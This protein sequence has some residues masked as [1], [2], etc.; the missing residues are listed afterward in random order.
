[1]DVAGRFPTGGG[2]PSPHHL[3]NQSG[4][5]CA[6]TEGWAGF[7]PHMVDNRAS[8]RWTDATY[9]DLEQDRTEN[10]SGMGETSFARTGPTGSE[11]HLVEGQVA[12][13]LWDVK[14]SRID[15][16][17]DKEGHNPRGRT[18]DDLAM[19]DDEIVGTLRAA[20]Y[21]S[22]GDFYAAWESARAQAHSARNV[23]ELHAMGFVGS[24]RPLVDPFGGLDKWTG[25]GTLNWR[26]GA[27]LEGGQPP[28]HQAGNTV[29]RARYC[30]GECVLTLRDGVDLSG[31]GAAELSLWRF[32]DN[33]LRAGDYLRVD[34]S[35]DGGSSWSA[36]RTWGPGS[37][38]DDRWHREAIPLT[39]YLD[40]TDFKVRLAAR[41][42][43][44][45]S[46]AAVDDVAINGTARARAGGPPDVLS[47]GFGTSLEGWT[48]RQV[49]AEGNNRMYCGGR[50]ST[51]YSLSHSQEHNGSAY[52]NH[53]RTCWFGAAG[54]ARTFSVPASLNGTDLNATARFQSFT[55]LPYSTGG[56]TNNL[57]ML[58][59]DSAGNVV[60]SGALFQGLRNTVVR[61]TGLRTATLAMPSFDAGRCP[62]TA[63]VHLNDHWRS[64]WDQRFYLDDLRI[65]GQAP[66]TCEISLAKPAMDV[67]SIARGT[68]ISGSDTQTV[69]NDG[70]LPVSSLSVAYSRIT[71]YDARGGPTSFTLPPSGAELRS[72]AA[73][74]AS[75]TPASSLVQFGS[76]PVGGSLDIQYRF[77]L[78]SATAIPAAVRQL[79]QT[80]TYNVVCAAAA[81]GAAAPPAGEGAP[82]A[83]PAPGHERAS[84]LRALIAPH[85]ATAPSPEGP[86]EPAPRPPGPPPPPPWAGPDVR[87]LLAG[88]PPVHST[89]KAHELL[90]MHASNGTRIMITEK[91]AYDADIVVDWDDHPGADRY[92]VVVHRAD[93]PRNRTADANV[94]ESR[95][96][97][98]GLDPSTEYVVRVGVRGDDST[99]ST[100]R[101]TT[102]PAG[103]AAL[104]PGLRLDASLRPASDRID[105]R[106][107]DT[108]GIRGDGRH[109]LELSVDGGPF[110]PAGASRTSSDSAEQ[111]IRPGWLGSTLAYRVSERIG[112]Q[113]H[114]YSEN[115]T[116]RLPASL[117]APSNLAVAPPSA[118]SGT[119]LSLGWDHA[120]LFRHYIV[121]AQRADG[122]WERIGRTQ[123]NSLDYAP[124]RGDGIAEYTFRVHAQL[125]SAASPPSDTATVRA[126]PP[127][128]PP[129]GGVSGAGSGP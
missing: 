49:P 4:A 24:A 101:A 40:S 20:T 99:Q 11:G 119:A 127:P 42:S 45:T 8:L 30:A 129:G 106:W 29:A 19:G 38:N 102:L 71:G 47:S 46:D 51:A 22:F 79:A 18:L 72:P 114:L 1:M 125:G 93:S 108:N 62:C 53:I 10:S 60:A 95:Y 92:K 118:A 64:N 2:C 111:A 82:P 77:N 56:H 13:A 110:G 17:F 126:A 7:V 48:Y 37:G 120:P 41:L 78:G 87:G 113:Q 75:W 3:H 96:R 128:P 21:S 25:S 97:F 12:A 105:L 54:M 33:H 43:Y 86:H 124:P 34:V 70:S 35:S 80:A 28:G 89:L 52:V 27:P 5:S 94:T 59:S 91:Y 117:Q 104:P 121:E 32:V 103:A 23:M 15:T 88:A 81:P 74:L 112:P 115:A 107:D 55:G 84:S 85:N 31:L 76:I 68:G 36:V 44:S 67:G 83:P 63:F 16:K 65:S 66:A 58:V 9:I 73:G 57:H 61:D 90:G 122:S 109:R 98:S 39:P 116:V 100:V 6:W 50:N 14:D 123:G 26:S 69:R